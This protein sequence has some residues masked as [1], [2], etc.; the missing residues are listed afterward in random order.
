MYKFFYEDW[1]NEMCI[2]RCN[3]GMLEL[4]SICQ[5]LIC[6][7]FS[8]TLVLSHLTY[9]IKMKNCKNPIFYNI[10]KYNYNNINNINR[11]LK[12]KRRTFKVK[13]F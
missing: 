3:E 11:R 7:V 6:I 10:I 4:Y 13:E 8:E 12:K 9:D 5:G 2:C 1:T